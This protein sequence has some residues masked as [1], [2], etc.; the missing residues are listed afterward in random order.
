MLLT[1]RFVAYITHI[2]AS[3]KLKMVVVFFTHAFRQYCDVNHEVE[4]HFGQ[5]ANVVEI[6]DDTEIPLQR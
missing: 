5:K 1:T 3:R 2:E 6:L 4:I